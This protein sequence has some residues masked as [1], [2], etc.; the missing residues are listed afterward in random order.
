MVFKVHVV[1]NIYD[2]I[3]HRILFEI[4]ISGNHPDLWD[5]HDISVFSV[6]EDTIEELT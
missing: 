6:D 1:R 3:E 5:F 4:R 2:T